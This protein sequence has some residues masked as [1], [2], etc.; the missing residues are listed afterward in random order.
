LY[1]HTMIVVTADHGEAFGE[2]NR[3]GHANSPYQNLLHVGLLIKY[4]NSMLKGTVDGSVSLVDVAPTILDTLGMSPPSTMQGRSL[5]HGVPG[6]RE[7][8]AEVFPCPVLHSPDCPNGCTARAVYSWPY[9]FITSTSGKRELYDLSA[10]PGETHDL[11]ASLAPLVKN[12]NSDLNEW[13]KRAPSPS[14]QTLRLDKESV[15]RL[16]SLGYAQ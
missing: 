11:S 6:P 15:Q 1:D 7:I 4:P 8:F 14:R 10:D 16:K 13:R 3:V 12:L 9:K 5:L 2:R